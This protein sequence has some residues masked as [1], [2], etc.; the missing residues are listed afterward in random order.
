MWKEMLGVETP[1]LTIDDQQYDAQ[2]LTVVVRET[3]G[4]A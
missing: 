4:L 2:E 1:C 3:I